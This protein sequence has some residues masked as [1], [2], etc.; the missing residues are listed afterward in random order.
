MDDEITTSEAA[1]LLGVQPRAVRWYWEKGLLAGR[2]LTPRMLLFKRADVEAFV[3]PI[4]PTGR[5]GKPDKGSAKKKTPV[6][7]KKGKPHAK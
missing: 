1:E 3:R 6:K 7:P 4:H 2:M 5:W